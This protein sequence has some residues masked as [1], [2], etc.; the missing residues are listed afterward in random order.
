MVLGSRPEYSLQESCN[1]DK[2]QDI[3]L[4][5]ICLIC[6]DEGQGKYLKFIDKVVMVCELCRKW[7][8]L[9]VFW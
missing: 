1:L 3:V 2:L 6:T 7:G 5:C 4:D 8:I 9:Y